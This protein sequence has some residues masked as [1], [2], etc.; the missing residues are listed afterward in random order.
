MAPASCFLGIFCGTGASTGTTTSLSSI[1]TSSISSYPPSSSASTSSA[2]VSSTGPAAASST[3]KSSKAGVYSNCY[4]TVDGVG[5]FNTR[6]VADWTTGVTQDLTGIVSSAYTVGSTSSSTTTT[7]SKVK[8]GLGSLFSLFSNSLSF[9]ILPSSVSQSVTTTGNSAVGAVGS[10][11]SGAGAAVA[12]VEAAMSSSTQLYTSY[13]DILYGSVRAVILLSNATGFT[14]F[15]SDTMEIDL[16]WLD[17]HSTY[18]TSVVSDASSAWHEYR[19]DWLPGSTSYYIDGNLVDST[20]SEAS[21]GLWL[22]NAWSDGNDDSVFQIRSIDAYFNRTSV[23]ADIANGIAVC[24][25]VSIVT[26]ATSAVSAT[27]SALG[28]LAGAATAAIG[29]V[30]SSASSSSTIPTPTLNTLATSTKTPSSSA[31]ATVSF[32]TISSAWTGKTTSTTTQLNG[33]AAT[34]IILTP[35][36]VQTTASSAPTSG[37]YVYMTSTTDSGTFTAVQT[38][39][40]LPTVGTVATVQIIYPT[41]VTTCGNTGIAYAGY[42]NSFAGGQS[43]YGY[44]KFNPTVYKSAKPTQTGVTNYIAEV[45]TPSQNWVI[46]HTFYLF[47][48]QDGYYSF[49]IPYTDDIQLVWYGDKA[50]SGWTRDNADIVQFW[51]SQIG[52]QTPQTIAVYLTTGS[53]L[54]IRLVYANGGGQG[55]LDFNIYAPDGSAVLASNKGL[56]TGSSSVDIVQFPCDGTLGANPENSSDSDSGAPP[57]KKVGELSLFQKPAVT[58]YTVIPQAIFSAATNRSQMFDVSMRLYRP[59]TLDEQPMRAHISDFSCI[60]KTITSKSSPALLAA[61]DTISLLQLGVSYQD[62]AFFEHARRRYGQALTAL[63]VALNKPNVLG[64]NDVLSAM[65]I[66]EF[67]E[68]IIFAEP[69]WLAVTKNTPYTDSSPRLFDILVHIPGLFERAD[70]LIASAEPTYLSGVVADLVTAIEQLQDWEAGYHSELK[71]PGFTNVDVSRFKRFT[72]L[73]HNKLFPLAIDFPDFLTGYLQSI[74][75]L[76]L[77]TIECTL[78]DVLMKYPGSKC[79]ISLDDLNKRV[80]QIAIYMCQMMPYFCEPDAASMGRFATFMPLVFA[81]RYFEARG[82]KSQQDWCQ[83]VTDAM[84]NDGINPPWKLD[85]AKG[86]E[87]A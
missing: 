48:R 29:G 71:D 39:T 16:N 55:E 20:A 15:R 41:P 62:Q 19:V 49:N 47:A 59:T 81:L 25:E 33:L 44:P 37:G 58:D 3:L 5:E 50:V 8:R 77:F 76:Y 32:T 31:Q 73:C 6:W 82:M 1:S 67:C 61:I 57:T 74:Y 45:N 34:V 30:A 24:K 63:V 2:V 23:N 70:N 52:S 9:R 64:N 46:D 75:W 7:S 54:P 51:S 11:A 66:L 4:Y 85:L 40:F 80:L 53:Y 42:T 27:T 60:Q 28:N 21:P 17:Y 68:A 86:L 13:N 87:P 65:K 78:Q 69:K 12:S 26:G 72:R 38:K 18:D 14:S 22:W 35:G 83:D 36:V 79:T 84:F 10:L 43:T 56:G